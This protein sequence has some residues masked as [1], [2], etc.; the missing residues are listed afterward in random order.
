MLKKKMNDYIVMKADFQKY[1]NI[2]HGRTS[3]EINWLV[4]E[5]SN[6]LSKLN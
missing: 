1:K 5:V 4:Y 3:E 2:N 6:N